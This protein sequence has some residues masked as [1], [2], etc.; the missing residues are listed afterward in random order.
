MTIDGEARHLVLGQAQAHRYALEA[1]LALHALGDAAAILVGDLDE[2]A[3]LAEQRA[4]IVDLLGHDLEDVCRRI[5]RERDAVAIV[6][7]AAG[8]R[9]RHDLDP[10]VLRQ[11]AE[12]LELD[13]LQL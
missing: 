6:D 13:H 9:Q 1:T 3:E 12:V 10:I 5:H 8:R 4:E 7:E 2:L 11:R